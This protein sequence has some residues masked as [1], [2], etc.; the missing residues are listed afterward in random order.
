M[1]DRKQI[2]QTIRARAAGDVPAPRGIRCSIVR[3]AVGIRLM[4]VRQQQGTPIAGGLLRVLETLQ[5]VRRRPFCAPCGLD[6][7]QGNRVFKSL[8]MNTRSVATAKSVR[9]AVRISWMIRSSI[10]ACENSPEAAMPNR[11]RHH[12]PPT[13]RNRHRV[14]TCP[15]SPARALPESRP[16]AVRRQ[17]SLQPNPP[18]WEQSLH[19]KGPVVETLSTHYSWAGDGKP[20]INAT[21]V[22]G[23][24]FL[25]LALPNPADCG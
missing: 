23:A 22:E 7:I 9:S 13:P 17:R 10:S 24:S 19:C 14:G 5:I 21:R 8:P 12:A 20:S 1:E 4:V 15:A 11:P 18:A 25:S 6:S 16:V 3:H 2:A